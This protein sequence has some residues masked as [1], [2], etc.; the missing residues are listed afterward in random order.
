M[1]IK[2]LF[3]T[4]KQLIKEYALKI[5]NIQMRADREYYKPH[6]KDYKPVEHENDHAAW[7]LDQVTPLK[8]MCQYLGIANE[9]YEEAYKI[10]D[11][12]NSGKKDFVPDLERLKNI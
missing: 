1:K 8:E 12:R 9:V 3:W 6:L 5:A 11:F 2:K 7:I 4:R 10:Y